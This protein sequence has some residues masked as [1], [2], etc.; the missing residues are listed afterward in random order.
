[1]LNA[2][3]LRPY[4]FGAAA[5]LLLTASVAVE[6]QFFGTS[7]TFPRFMT[8]ILDTVGI[9]L[10]ATEFYQT[11]GGSLTGAAFPNWQLLFVIGIGVGAFV[12][13]KLSG[14]YKREELPQMWVERFGGSVRTRIWWSLLGGTLAIVGARMAG[15]CPSGHGISGLSQLGVSSFLA[16]TMFF[17]GGIVTSR[18]LYKGGNV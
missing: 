2:K 8:L 14:T 1:M 7:T 3:S 15:G 9:D 5:G 10:S 13:S 12:S 17:V 11:R 4:L 18:I 16:L 6:G